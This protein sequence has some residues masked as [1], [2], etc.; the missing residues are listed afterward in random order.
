M[1]GVFTFHFEPFIFHFALS[2]ATAVFSAA[3]WI[4]FTIFTY[5]VQRQIW[6]DIP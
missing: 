1:H 6:P 5:P 4:A 2:G 3:A